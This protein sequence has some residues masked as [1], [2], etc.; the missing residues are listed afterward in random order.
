MTAGSLR[1]AVQDGNFGRYFHVR[2]DCRSAAT[3]PPPVSNH[4][5]LIGGAE[6]VL[7]ARAARFVGKK[8][9]HGIS[10]HYWWFPRYWRRNG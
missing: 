2:S 8:G 5:K 7:A 6:E 4:D 3:S 9:S 10:N 1:K